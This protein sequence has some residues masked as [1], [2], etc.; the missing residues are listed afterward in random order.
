M[1][2]YTVKRMIGLAVMAGV[3]SLAH[4]SVTLGISSDDNLRAP[5]L[6]A[7]CSVINVPAGNRLV[8]R[9]YALGVQIYKWN[10]TGWDFVAPEANLF[11]SKRYRGKEGTHYAGPIWESDS[12]SYVIARRT[13]GCDPD[14]TAISWLLLEAVE[15]DG[16]GVYRDVTYI[17]RVNTRGGLKPATAGA[18]VGEEVRVPYTTEYYFYKERR[19]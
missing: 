17:Q 8:H 10:G 16:P 18:F 2:I 14:P 15:T 13:Q 12:G 7:V 1:N 4:A 5:E 6:P 11:T 9:T 3:V 19:N